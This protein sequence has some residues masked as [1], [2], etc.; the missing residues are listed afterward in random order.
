MN[1][2]PPI[3]TKVYDLLLYLVPQVAKFPRAQ[4]YA[5]GERLEQTGFDVLELLLTAVYAPEK[6][7]IL[8]EAN[9]KLEQTRYYVRFTKDLKLI[10][11]HRYEILSKMIN[12]VG[13]QLGGWLKQQRQRI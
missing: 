11:I 12:D 3:I 13:I 2:A 4:R 8:Q 1:A 6:T 5:L 9:I 7:A 10:N